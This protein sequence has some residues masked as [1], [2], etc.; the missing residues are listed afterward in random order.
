MRLGTLTGLL[1]L[2]PTTALA[3]EFLDDFDDN[4]LAPWVSEHGT[5]TVANGHYTGS[6][7]STHI[8]PSATVDAG[9]PAGRRLLFT[10]DVTRITGGPGFILRRNGGDFCGFHL[11][12]NSP[13]L[14]LSSENPEEV[15]QG[16]LGVAA[17][18]FG[19]TFELQAEIDQANFLTLRVNGVD[20]W[21]GTH[22]WC[23]ITDTGVVGIMHHSGS[24]SNWD[25]YSVQWGELDA[26]GDGYCAGAFCD[27]PTGTPGDC[28]DTDASVNPLGQEI[29]GGGDE[30]C[31][32][33]TDDADPSVTGLLVWYADTDSDTFGDV[34][35]TTTAC[36]Q[37]TGFVSDSTD[38]ND[39]ATGINPGAQELCSGI[40]EDC[41]GLIDDADSSVSGQGA[42]YADADSDTYGDTNAVTISCTQPAGTVTDAT[43]CDD[44]DASINIA[45]QEVCGGADEDCDG[46]VDD[47]DPSAIGQSTWYLDSDGDTFGD[48]TATASACAAPASHVADATDCDDAEITTFPGAQEACDNV[49]SDCDGD[50]VD[51]FPDNDL[52]GDP[53]CNDADDDN[54]GLSDAD[55]VSL[56]TDPNNPDSDGDGADDLTEVGDPFNPTDSDGDTI[57]DA[58]DTDDDGDGIDSA[59]EGFGDSDGD[60][61]PNALDDD[62]D[63]DGMTDLEEGDGDAD[64]DGVANFLDTDSDGN[65]IDDGT[66]G[67][68]DVDGDGI[69]DFLDVDDTDGP[70]ADPDGDGLTNGEEAILGTD[71]A[72]ADSDGDGLDDGAEVG[73]PTNATDSDGDTVIDALDPDDDGDGISTADELS[74]DADGDGVADEDVDGDGTPNYLDDDSDDDGL[75]DDY[76]GDGD[77]DGDGVPDYVDTDSDGDGIDDDVEGDG[78]TDGDGAPDAYD[79]DSDGDGIPDA[80]EGE[81]DVDGDGLGNWIDT[82]ADGDGMSDADEGTGDVDNDGT[83]NWLDPDDTDGPTADADGDGLTNEE[84]A[85]LGTDAYDEDT[86]DDGL[87][88]GEEVDGTGTDPTLFDTDGDG[89]GDGDELDDG[90][91][92]LD[93]DSDDDGLDDGE[94]AAAGTDPLD[95]DTD[96]DGMDD[97]TE[98]DN[99]A[100]PLDEDTDDDGILDGPDGLGDDDEDGLINVLDAVDD[101]EAEVPDE[102]LPVPDPPEEVPECGCSA[103]ASPTSPGWLLLLLV[104]L[105][106][107]RPRRC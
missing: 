51:G 83:P 17:M 81:G 69:A 82:D 30:D 107:R 101:R 75:T 93:P 43:D 70:L 33:L 34:N 59:V 44:G 103:A 50:L 73:D 47:D 14:Y 27:D 36:A 8:T 48:V 3:G 32:G 89:I 2:L 53:D 99:G 9:F 22:S 95:A 91:D 61:T 5:N 46:L 40:D 10:A 52:D 24:T 64:G 60:G 102:E 18:D 21:S 49:D 97:G 29:C 62:S 67:N 74:V 23:N 90:T 87:L 65:G 16:N 37:P 104:P 84:E 35:A 76:E 85:A 11:W 38:C 41:D 68:G 100:D 54:D 4:T 39:T 80:T 58:I 105:L 63:G 77:F 86:D 6:N 55:E 12:S 88:D 56:G 19:F 15:N 78:D 71:G 106:R 79:L 42:W 25:N 72:N 26:D 94:E 31:D 92:P 96:D 98:V 66:D 57:I 1:L 28:D 20:V 7:F 45:G 13:T